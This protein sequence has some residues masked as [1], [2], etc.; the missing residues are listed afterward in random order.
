MLLTSQ[1]ISP[2]C[3][4]SLPNDLNSIIENSKSF[5]LKKHD[6]S[7][8][9]GIIKGTDFGLL[10]DLLVKRFN[11]RGFLDFLLHR[12]FNSRAKRLWNINLRLYEKGLPVP[13]PVAYIESSLKQKNS[14]FI[15]FVID[16]ADNLGNIYRKGILNIDKNILKQLAETVVTWHLKGA[17]HGDLKWPNI[18][19]QENNNE[20]KIFFIDLD[21]SRLY[22]EPYPKGIIKDLKRF[23]RF[24]LELGAEKWVESE[25]FPEYIAIV[26]D[27]IKTKIDLNTVKNDA[28]KDWHKKG[29]KRV[30]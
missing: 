7:T 16:N 24:G 19:I 20:Y 13:K 27:E 18:L 22:S 5:S 11:Y 25:F 8:T 2:D 14:F 23:Y 12:I 3:T 21:Q 1:A 29:G 10:H 28:V 15:S 6:L 26:P 9:V 30:S 4:L 17:V